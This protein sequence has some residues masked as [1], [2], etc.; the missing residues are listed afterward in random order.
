M[1]S[2]GKRG[3]LRIKAGII[4][5]VTMLLIMIGGDYS[6]AKIGLAILPIE[7]IGLSKDDYSVIVD[8]FTLEI[9]A[10]K[11]FSLVERSLLDKVLNEQALGQ[12]GAIDPKSIANIGKLT[13]A[14]KMVKCKVYK[15][16]KNYVMQAD[17]IDV[18]TAQIEHNVKEDSGN[19]NS[20]GSWVAGNLALRY[21]L[22]GKVI[23]STQGDAV[24]ELG[25]NDGI[26]NGEILFWAREK[27]S[28]DEKGN[29]LFAKTERMGKLRATDISPVASQAQVI[30]KVSPDAIPQK[31]DIVSPEPIPLKEVPVQR[32]P[33]FSNIKLGKLILDDDMKKIKYL[34]PRGN[35]GDSYVKGTLWDVKLSL[36][37]THKTSGN[38]Y[39]FYPSPYDNL[40]DFVLEGETSFVKW[41]NS[42]GSSA[43]EIR[44]NNIYP[45][46]EGYGFWFSA[47][48]QYSIQRARARQHIPIIKWESTPDLNRG[49]KANKFKIVAVGPKIDFYINDIFVAAFLD[50]Y[51][52]CGGVG[53]FAQ[54]GNQVTFDNIKIWEWGGGGNP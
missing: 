15:T 37:A 2:I 5:S 40:K 48:G 24:V 30:E 36:D 25:E 27:V 22:I 34:S 9:V 50:E 51:Y 1:K 19:V 43:I 16:G 26:R 17:V 10:S 47:D 33:F 11:K 6:Y 29:I 41:D 32:T 54:H 18:N 13:G 52:C 46:G 7:N 21:P 12:S 4:V 8:K 23:G 14:D 45:S 35:K 3:F 31:D 53:L 28:K 44:S 20:P 49:E 38:T 39:A 42:G